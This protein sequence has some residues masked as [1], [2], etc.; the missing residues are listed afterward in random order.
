[1]FTIKSSNVRSSTVSVEI[2]ERETENK[3]PLFGGICFF[4]KNYKNAK[5]IKLYAKIV[6]KKNQL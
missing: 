3:S 4:E 2:A 1:M 5:F 6:Q